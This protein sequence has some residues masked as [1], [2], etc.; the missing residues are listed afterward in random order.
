MDHL[1]IH[2]RNYSIAVKDDADD[3]YYDILID[4]PHGILYKSST[5]II[6]HI[7]D[8]ISECTRN[9]YRQLVIDQHEYIKV[10]IKK[11][12]DIVA[13]LPVLTICN[14]PQIKYE[15][16]IEYNDISYSRCQVDNF[17]IYAENC[18][19]YAIYNTCNIRFTPRNDESF[20]MKINLKITDEPYNEQQFFGAIKSYFDDHIRPLANIFKPMKCKSANK[21]N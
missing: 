19:L 17:S 9:E 11:F 6:P 2:I 21:L 3:L 5:L 14:Q 16:I 4:K 18:H 8:M 20:Y 10:N 7:S 15:N 12:N 13:D 1:K